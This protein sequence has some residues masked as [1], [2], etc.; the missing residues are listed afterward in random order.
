MRLEEERLD[1]ESG[2][3]PP[4]RC[5]RVPSISK[6]RLATFCEIGCGKLADLC[7]NDSGTA[8]GVNF[9]GNRGNIKRVQFK[10]VEFVHHPGR[11]VRK[12]MELSQWY[13]RS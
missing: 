3:D 12:P 13:G 9:D 6:T 10:A 7:R 5:R 8:H 2:E 1:E 11:T 4:S